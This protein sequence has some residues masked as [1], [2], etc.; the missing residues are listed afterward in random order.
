MDRMKLQKVLSPLDEWSFSYGCLLGWAAFSMPLTVFL[1]Q[2]GLRGSLLGFAVGGAF[3]A[4][5]AL[6]YYYLTLQCKGN[7][8]IFYL[9][10]NTMG[11]P[12]A[13]AAAWGISF[14]HLLIIPLN[15]RAF[16]R[17]IHALLQEY[18]GITLEVRVFRLNVLVFDLLVIVAILSLFAFI[19]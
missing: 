17:L 4:V 8:G 16:V 11:R 14:A 12:H 15:A 10:Y 2:S 18:T 3:I 19:N 7:G 5:I 9:L 13:Y 6:N 1:P